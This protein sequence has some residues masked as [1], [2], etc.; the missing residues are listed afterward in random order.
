MGVVKSK[1]WRRKKSKTKN[2]SAP[3]SKP[4]EVINE[5]KEDKTIIDKILEHEEYEIK[6]EEKKVSCSM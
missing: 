6:D 1:Y 4:N 3:R 5:S 2:T